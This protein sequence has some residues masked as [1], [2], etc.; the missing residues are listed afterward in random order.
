MS[1]LENTIDEKSTICIYNC[2]KC[3][4]SYTSRSGL[5]KH[6]KICKTLSILE[7][8]KE[9]I[10]TIQNNKELLDYIKNENLILTFQK[11]HF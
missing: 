2:K 11:K 1:T 3:N 4:K 8:N 6:T 9:L 5:W 7:I 10:K